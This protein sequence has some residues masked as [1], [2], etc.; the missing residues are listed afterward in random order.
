VEAA[1]TWTATADRTCYLVDFAQ[2]DRARPATTNTGIAKYKYNQNRMMVQNVSPDWINQHNNGPNIWAGSAGYTS[3]IITANTKWY[4]VSLVNKNAIGNIVSRVSRYMFYTIDHDKK[5]AWSNICGMVEGVKFYW[6]NRMGGIDSYVAKK[7]FQNSID[8]NQQTITRGTP[9]RTYVR[10]TSSTSA[11]SSSIDGNIYP[12]TREV[13]NV[14]ANRNYTVYTDPLT[15]A[16]AKWIE[17]LLTSPNVWV[18]QKNDAY[19]RLE[20]LVATDETR[21]SDSG[22]MPVLITNS[23]TNLIDEEQGLVQIG[24]EF[25]ESNPINSQ[26]N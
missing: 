20:N 17:E 2:N 15:Q 23:T 9:W 4:R 22:Y 18:L 3:S 14:D 21:P 6:L 13:L 25:T 5:Y 1:D 19:G 12:H 7:T 8:V 10:D 16:E 11:K 24:I 26:R